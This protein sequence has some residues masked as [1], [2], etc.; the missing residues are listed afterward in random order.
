[1]DDHDSGT[2]TN[3]I[4]VYFL[5][6]RIIETP[7]KD[8]HKVKTCVG[9]A[10]YANLCHTFFPPEPT[11]AT[12]A[13]HSGKLRDLVRIS[14]LFQLL[15]FSMFAHYSISGRKPG[16]MRLNLGSDAAGISATLPDSK[17]TSRKPT[18]TPQTECSWRV[19]ILFIVL[20]FP[21]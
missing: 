2:F 11:A 6:I 9:Q 7:K 12:T 20:F 21:F 18:K 17:F 1:M 4:L 19:R 15:L 13:I 3:N 5:P 14:L 8:D 16:C 10:F